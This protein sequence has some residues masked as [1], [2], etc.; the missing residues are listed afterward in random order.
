VLPV[1]K[2]AGSDVDHS[3]HFSAEIK[4]EWSH[5]STSTLGLHGMDGDNFTFTFCRGLLHETCFR[6]VGLSGLFFFRSNKDS[7]SRQIRSFLLEFFLVY[8][9]YVLASQFFG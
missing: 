9:T 8:L 3:P 6:D 1:A 4:N 5:M 7:S 2:W